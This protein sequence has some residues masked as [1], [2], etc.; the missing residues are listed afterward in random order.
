MANPECSA[1]NS[2]YREFLE[3][4]I[5]L[6][7]PCGFDVDRRKLPK[8]LFDWQ[9]DVV[10]WALRQGRCALFLDAGL[11][12]TGQQLAW[13]D[14]VTKYTGKPV[15]VLAPLA[16]SHQ[17]VRESGKFGIKNVAIAESAADVKDAKVYV[18]NYHKL[19]KFDGIEFSGVVVDESSI[20]KDHDGKFRNMLIDRFAKTP[21]RL[22]ASAT[23]S[24]NDHEELGNH[25]EFLGISSRVEMLATYFNH[26]S[27]DTGEWI[28]KKHGEKS[29]W[30][31]VAS[32]AMVMRK[33][34]DLGYE[35]A[36]YD[37]PELKII[38]HDLFTG[39]TGDRLF[40]IGAESLADQRKA[41]RETLSARV[42]KAAELVN[43]SDE[44]WVIWCELNDEGDLLEKSIRDCAQI[45]GRHN[46]EE[47]VDRIL[48]FA[49]GRY[50]NLVSKPSLTGHGLNWQHCRNMVFVG[51][52]HSFELFYQAFRRCW[53][54]GQ[55]R[56]VNVHIIV[57][58][59][60]SSV[61]D[62]VMRKMKAHDAMFSTMVQYTST[63]N[64]QSLSGFVKL[65]TAYNPQTTMEIPEWLSI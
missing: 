38:Q 45:A 32:W 35:C 65:E 46:D 44:Q 43:N 21:Y 31:W 26:D 62:N 2:Q 12:K 17:S 63:M 40:C 59:Q 14:Q 6:H 11:G 47:K 18:T 60:E 30:N 3:T 50:R 53:R 25:A 24:P 58:D 48:G 9:K 22:A 28:L 64:Q 5:K 7:D 13:S 56:P 34:S 16:V 8:I 20:M 55:T 52:S 57:S 33:P 37:L 29:F 61:V 39:K 15:L 4:K 19:H 23:P 1:R 41:R 42:A 27:A 49:D 54:Y 10:S 36:G 51:L